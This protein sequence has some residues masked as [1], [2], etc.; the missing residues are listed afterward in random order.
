MLVTSSR[1]LEVSQVVTGSI[2]GRFQ[3]MQK[4]DSDTMV[5]RA[6][7]ETEK[8]VTPDEISNIADLHPRSV[9]RS[10]NRLLKRGWVKETREICHTTLYQSDSDE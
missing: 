3:S 6:L 8:D 1:L 4:G 7:C 9:R 2:D 10:L 5:Y